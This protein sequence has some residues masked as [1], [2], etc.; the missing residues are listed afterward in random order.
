VGGAPALAKMIP[1]D[2]FFDHGDSVET[3]NPGGAKL[4]N[5]K[6]VARQANIVKRGD[7]IR[8]R[9]VDVIVGEL[10]RVR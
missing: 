1:I 3:D 4:G 6:T 9:G 5:R 8:S 10:R 7:K 2:R